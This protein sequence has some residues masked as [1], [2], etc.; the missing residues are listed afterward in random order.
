[1]NTIL[2]RLFEPTPEFFKNIRKIGLSVVAIVA[3]VAMLQPIVIEAGIAFPSWITTTVKIFTASTGILTTLL[4]SLASTW[5]N[6]DGS[7]NVQKKIDDGGY[8]DK[9]YLENEKK[10]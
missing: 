5:R 6:P 9:E 2:Q 7:I 1:M 10:E 8:G 4:A 3:F